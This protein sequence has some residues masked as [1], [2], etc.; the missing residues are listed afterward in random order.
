LKAS[1]SPLKR[2]RSTSPVMPRT[3]SRRC[4][5]GCFVHRVHKLGVHGEGPLAA[6]RS[7]RS[8]TRRPTT[9]RPVDVG[10]ARG[11][12]PRSPRFGSSRK[13][14]ATIS[15]RSFRSCAKGPPRHCK[16]PAGPIALAPSSRVPRSNAGNPQPDT[17]GRLHLDPRA[18]TPTDCSGCADCC[19]RSPT[20]CA[21]AVS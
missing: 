10:R 13:C 5:N 9:P 20:A 1:R 21:S 12:D 4:R 19:R 14:T 16:P 2:S 6:G 11:S 3:H 8:T 15:S 7:R 18:A 17:R